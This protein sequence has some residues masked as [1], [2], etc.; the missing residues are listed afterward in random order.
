MNVL[1]LVLFVTLLIFIGIGMLRGVVREGMSLLSWTIAALAGAL[2]NESV[3][4][5]FGWIAEPVLRRVL[6]FVIIFA[7][8][9]LAAT[10]ATFLLRVVVGGGRVG[11]GARA[12]G[13]FLGAV[14]AT[15][16]IVALVLLAGLTS[17]PQKTWWQESRLMVVFESLAQTVRGGLPDDMANQVIYR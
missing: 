8:V 16:V 10:V 11:P 4:T 6:A 3:G 9:Y 1:D 14:R 17:I 12:G 15:V 5:W 13:A 2:F 7:T